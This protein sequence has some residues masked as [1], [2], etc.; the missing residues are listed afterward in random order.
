MKL[1]LISGVVGMCAVVVGAMLIGTGDFT[2]VNENLKFLE[3]LDVRVDE[4]G[5]KTNVSVK[6]GD[7][8]K[9]GKGTIVVRDDDRIEVS[10][11]KNTKF[12]E[13]NFVFEDSK[14]KEIKIKGFSANI[15]IS[16]STDSK[17]FT[18][19]ME[20]AK[21][22]QDT[23]QK[24]IQEQAG[25]LSIEGPGHSGFKFGKGQ[26]VKNIEIEFP[27]SSTKKLNMDLGAGNIEIEEAAFSE[28]Q[29]NTGAGNI[30]MDEVS[31]NRLEIKN[32]AGKIALESLDARG[33]VLISSGTGAI[34]I[35]SLNP[36]PNITVK[37]G[38][39]SIEFKNKA[40]MSDY[41][42]KAKTGIGSVSLPQADKVVNGYSYFGSGKGTVELKTG[43]G[44][45]K[46]K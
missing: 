12:T 13:E 15:E 5:D 20:C 10:L 35:E 22:Y 40:K 43:T 38:A 9:G 23:C 7:G 11:N 27:A 34:K 42:I 45:I 1:F 29:L 46:V 8:T 28:V 6:L 19:E 32:G 39:G 3:N 25:V 36:E 33:E 44:S 4:S 26:I 37:T 17:E 14:I 2:G 30:S 21:E 18:I 31:V 16:G 41:K 24:M